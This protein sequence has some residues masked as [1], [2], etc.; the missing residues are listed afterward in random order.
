MRTSIISGSGATGFPDLLSPLSPAPFEIPIAERVTLNPEKPDCDFVARIHAPDGIFLGTAFLV[1]PNYVVTCR[2]VLTPANE[3]MKTSCDVLFSGGGNEPN[4]ILG[5]VEKT[6]GT[7]EENSEGYDLV[8][9]RLA[10]APGTRAVRLLKGFTFSD[11]HSLARA[12]WT[13]IGYSGRDASQYRRVEVIE[14][15]PRFTAT[16]DTGSLLEAQID[17]GIANGCSGGPLLVEA[18]REWFCLGMV[19]VGGE[20]SA[21]SRFVL[22]DC[23]VD[24]LERTIPGQIH[25]LPRKELFDNYDV[26]QR[27][28]KSVNPGVASV[29]QVAGNP[30]GPRVSKWLSRIAVLL[31]AVALVLLNWKQ[32]VS[33]GTLSPP[34][35]ASK[36]PS[37]PASGAAVPTNR[38]AQ[39]KLYVV[40]VAVYAGS[41]SPRF[42]VNG[43]STEPDSY[44][45]GMAKFSLPSG[46][47]RITA[48]YP[49]RRCEA[50]VSLPAASTV[51]APCHLK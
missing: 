9:V 36:S 27:R 30:F 10:D 34:V 37:L 16:Q 18:S 46:N 3:S 41:D 5:T 17:H 23:I 8:L 13:V 12:E 33:L 44:A 35:P 45:G 6:S 2:H 47:Y 48:E 42:A 19:Y 51:P 7:Q 22:A 24:F 14:A 15:P 1:A 38:P 50:F 29:A 4:R 11:R 20:A 40:T 28:P 32:P 21:T 39:R 31:L 49:E 26:V 25:P 43:K